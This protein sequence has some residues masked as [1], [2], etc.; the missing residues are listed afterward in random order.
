[1]DTYDLLNSDGQNGQIPAPER[2]Q[3]K[4]IP[5]DDSDPPASAASVSRKPLTMGTNGSPRPQP[6]ARPAPVA[7]KR[8]VPRPV[9]PQ[10]GA[11]SK[12]VKKAVHAGSSRIT[13][14]KTFYTKLH[15]GALDFIDE[16]IAEWLKANPTVSI[17]STNVT[18][19]DVQSKKTEANIII[20]IWY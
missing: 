10:A 19:G 12:Q 8:P 4:P 16:Q 1:M 17:K 9:S 2:E 11:V 13:G 20:S 7:Q 18:V 14:L 15:P 6:A 5:F 3:D